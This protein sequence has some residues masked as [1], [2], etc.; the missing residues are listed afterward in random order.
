M[1][2]VGEGEGRRWD[3]LQKRVIEADCKH[4]YKQETKN[5]GW[6]GPQHQLPQG[7]PRPD[8]EGLRGLA[9]PR[10]VSGYILLICHTAQQ[11]SCR[12]QGPGLSPSPAGKEGE[13]CRA[14]VAHT[15]PGL[16]WKARVRTPH[17]GWQWLAGG[18]RG[19]KPWTWCDF[20]VCQAPPGEMGGR[21]S[22]AQPD[23][24]WRGGSGQCSRWLT[25]PPAH[26]S[27]RRVKGRP[28]VLPPKAISPLKRGPG[29]NRAP[30]QQVDFGACP[31][32]EG[33]GCQ[34]CPAGRAL[35]LARAAPPQVPLCQSFPG[36][37]RPSPAW[38]FVFLNQIKEQT[39]SF[40][41][42]GNSSAVPHSC[43]Q[44][45]AGGGMEGE[46]TVGRCG[47][48]PV[49]GRVVGAPF[50]Q[51]HSTSRLPCPRM[52]SCACA[53]RRGE[54]GPSPSPQPPTVP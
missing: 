30:G 20:L 25:A 34:V 22:L 46:A 38:L 42:F 4:Y 2:S 19:Q 3:L 27:A 45:G 11:Q 24:A 51:S 40:G 17:L 12:C 10:T 29:R 41:K 31:K 21:G 14:R 54:P 18:P 15:L 9:P 48:P 23:R 6:G 52:D 36:A 32:G 50:P 35:P 28:A 7:S 49:T 43:G 33:K 1:A 39:S 37:P 5:R 26:P 44:L 13:L 16:P 53:K 47:R 8:P